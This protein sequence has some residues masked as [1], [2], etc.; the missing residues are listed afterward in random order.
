MPGEIAM[1]AEELVGLLNRGD[2]MTLAQRVNEAMLAKHYPRAEYATLTA[3]LGRG[4]PDVV[5]PVISPQP[6]AA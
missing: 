3:H 5:I 2:L 6:V 4:V 1:T